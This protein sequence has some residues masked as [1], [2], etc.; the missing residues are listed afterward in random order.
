MEY[1]MQLQWPLSALEHYG[2]A[3]MKFALIRQ[4]NT[5]FLLKHDLLHIVQKNGG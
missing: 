1:F 5:I 3:W 2:T 4:S